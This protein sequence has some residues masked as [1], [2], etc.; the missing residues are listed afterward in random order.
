MRIGAQ[1]GVARTT[2]AAR[3][4]IRRDLGSPRRWV[5]RG[6]HVFGRVIH[7]LLNVEKKLRRRGK[8]LVTGWMRW[9][10]Q[11]VCHVSELY[12]MS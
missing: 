8:G 10:L 9:D 6:R 12:C 2:P 7:V 5:V 4:E 3:V 1:C 11:R